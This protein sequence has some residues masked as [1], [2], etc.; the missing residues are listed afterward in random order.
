MIFFGCK[1]SQ[2]FKISG[3]ELVDPKNVKTVTELLE[4]G[5]ILVGRFKLSRNYY[6]LKPGQVYV[7]DKDKQIFHPKSGLPASH[8]V[9]IMGVGRRQTRWSEMTGSRKPVYTNHMVMQ[10]SEGNMFGINGIG[11]VGKNSVMELYRIYVSLDA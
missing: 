2:V 5:N 6:S 10:N 7:Y 3:H 11:R 9:M 8:G 1:Q 4:L